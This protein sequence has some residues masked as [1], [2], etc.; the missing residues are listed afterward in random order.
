VPHLADQHWFVAS[1][2]ELSRKKDARVQ[3]L[4]PQIHNNTIAPC[5]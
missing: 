2:V 3:L 5:N 1:G 4:R